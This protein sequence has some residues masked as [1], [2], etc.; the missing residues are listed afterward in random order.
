V[1]ADEGWGKSQPNHCVRDKK[2]DLRKG[3]IG[4]G[5]EVLLNKELPRYGTPDG[6]AN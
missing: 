2:D 6:G 4:T 3:V 1:V 5:L